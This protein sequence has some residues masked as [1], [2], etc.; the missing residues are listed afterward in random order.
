MQH[1]AAYLP[2]EWTN[3]VSHHLLPL[4]FVKTFCKY[5][6]TVSKHVND[7]VIRRWV[8]A[9]HYLFD[10]ESADAEL[11][12]RCSRCEVH[13]SFDWNMISKQCNGSCFKQGVNKCRSNPETTN[14]HSS[15]RHLWFSLFAYYRAIFISDLF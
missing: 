10:T 6:P 2:N 4:A 9:V 8:V 3:K 7:V 15:R 13:L 11:H 14:D 12:S 1:C 5:R